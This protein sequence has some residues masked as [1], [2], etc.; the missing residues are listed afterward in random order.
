MAI[1]VK[2]EHIVDTFGFGFSFED[3]ELVILLACW[4]WVI[5][6]APRTSA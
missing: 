2:T 1:R 4:M 5:Y 6:S 3:G